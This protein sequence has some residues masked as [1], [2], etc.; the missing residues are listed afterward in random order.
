M[1]TAELF[2]LIS[3]L[4]VGLTDRV[5]QRD[6][7]LQAI[8]PVLARATSAQ[9][10]WVLLQAFLERLQ[11]SQ[12]LLFKR[13]WHINGQCYLATWGLGWYLR[14]QA[15]DNQGKTNVDLGNC[16]ADSNALR[17]PLAPVVGNLGEGLLHDGAK[18]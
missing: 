4:C 17:M 2:E 18:A 10:L 13:D 5:V 15:N 12:C 11:P 7:L 6:E 9:Q 3:S 14:Q 1:G 8:E 16:D